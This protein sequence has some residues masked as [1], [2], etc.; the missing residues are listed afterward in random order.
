MMARWAQS[1]WALFSPRKLEVSHIAGARVFAICILGGPWLKN[2]VSIVLWKSAIA[3]EV[4][5]FQMLFLFKISCTVI[6]GDFRLPCL[7][8]ASQIYS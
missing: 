6:G 5:I 2:G 1:E 4:S 3:M 7:V 8:G